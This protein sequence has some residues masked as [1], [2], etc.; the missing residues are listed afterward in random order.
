MLGVA[1]LIIV[2]SVMGGFSTKLRERLH[3]LL[4]DVL[5]E[6]SSMDGFSDPAG[7]MA[8]IREDPFLREQVVAM[9]PTMEVFAL[10]QFRY[11]NGVPIS[12][13]VRLIGIDPKS[14]EQIGSFRKH[15]IYPDQRDD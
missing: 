10:L 15:V 7:K 4:S 2:N 13:P 11:P 12:R 14:R 3:S 5:V 9:A 8:L 1:T 6:A